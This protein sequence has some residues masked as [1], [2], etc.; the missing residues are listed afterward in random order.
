MHYFSKYANSIT[1][2]LFKENMMSLFFK[3]FGVKKVTPTP[4]PTQVEC[5]NAETTFKPELNNIDD[6]SIQ[7]AY[8]VMNKS[9]MS[10]DKGTLENK[11]KEF[12]KAIENI[13]QK[14]GTSLAD[15]TMG[16]IFKALKNIEKKES[17]PTKHK[18]KM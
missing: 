1:T 3:I 8:Y 10:I 14:P 16:D 4:A 11:A 7:F 9:G 13:M 2:Q 6:K 5:I 18:R 17:D 12:K 15:I